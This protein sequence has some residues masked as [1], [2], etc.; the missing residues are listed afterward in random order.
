MAN[1]TH[2]AL[3][4]TAVMRNEFSMVELRYLRRGESLS[5]VIT[6]TLNGNE[7]VL[8]STELECLARAPHESFRRLL[9]EIDTHHDSQ[10][11][12]AMRHAPNDCTGLPAH[13]DDDGKG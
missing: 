3:P 6:D 12:S 7:I 5:L 4:P 8:D 1:D 10:G 2:N 9:R 11:K 13:G